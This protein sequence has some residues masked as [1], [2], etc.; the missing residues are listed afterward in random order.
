MTPIEIKTP[1]KKCPVC[2]R[3]FKTFEREGLGNDSPS[4]HKHEVYHRLPMCGACKKEHPG[5][6]EKQRVYLYN[7]HREPVNFYEP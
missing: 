2:G 5:G 3:F 1:T 4:R 6:H 7:A